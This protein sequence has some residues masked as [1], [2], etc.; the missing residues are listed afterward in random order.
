MN[1][2][3]IVITAAC[4]GVSA[5]TCAV[6]WAWDAAN[7][8]RI[9]RL[10][11]ESD[12][13]QVVDCEDHGPEPTDDEVQMLLAGAEKIL[14]DYQTRWDLEDISRLPIPDKLRDRLRVRVLGGERLAD[15]YRVN[16]RA[17]Q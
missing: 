7:T 13:P 15:M 4:T 14:T 10:L 9:Q 2:T 12:A 17:D 1:T 3:T 8:R 5:L 16:G 6:F 11:A